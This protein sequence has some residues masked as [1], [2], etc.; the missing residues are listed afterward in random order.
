MQKTMI[1]FLF[2]S[3]VVTSKAQQSFDIEINSIQPTLLVASAGEEPILSG[4]D[5][6]LGGTPT[7]LGGIEP[8]QYQWLPANSLDSPTIANPIFTGSSSTTYTLVLSDSRGCSASDTVQIL[9]LSMDN[10]TD[11]D[12]LKA[13][14]NPG[15][16]KFRII[17][18]NNLNLSKTIIYVFD[19]TGRA[20]YTNTIANSKQELLLDLSEL[21]NGQYTL[22]FSDGSLNVSNKIIIQ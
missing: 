17:A 8:Y 15:S 12:V 16:G 14:P 1:V 18:P 9:I 10:V 19:A 2:A 11:E 3:L 22:T 6:V 20:V 7:G 21:A 13:Y 4:F 5:L